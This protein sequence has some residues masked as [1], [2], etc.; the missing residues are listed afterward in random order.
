M[1]D[2][3]EVQ[4]ELLQES[5]LFRIV[6]ITLHYSITILQFITTNVFQEK[7]F[8]DFKVLQIERL[9]NTSLMSTILFSLSG[10]LKLIE[11]KSILKE[12]MI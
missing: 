9:V 3:S 1:A 11:L 8:F 4:K 12:K 5:E 10:T 6:A 2:S 7:F